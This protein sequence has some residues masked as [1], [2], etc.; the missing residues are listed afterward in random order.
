[1]EIIK[2]KEKG[3][4][5]GN[6]DTYCFLDTMGVE[7]MASHKDWV[8]FKNKE[9]VSIFMGI[10]ENGEIKKTYEPNSIEI[11]EEMLEFNKMYMFKEV[12]SSRKYT[13]FDL[14]FN[15]KIK[16]TK[17]DGI[18]CYIIEEKNK[19]DYFEQNTGLLRGSES[20]AT[21]N[22]IYYEFNCVND[23]MIEKPD[24]TGMELSNNEEE[25]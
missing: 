23:D 2:N 6:Y 19:K 15:I 5:I 22:Y 16:S 17:F 7:F 10:N 25:E 12:Y 13:L 8:D 24:T 9:T 20:D 1:M 3:I 21:S 18:D 14:R 11:P 4:E